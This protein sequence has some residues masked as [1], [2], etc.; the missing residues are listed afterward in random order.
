MCSVSDDGISPNLLMERVVNPGL[1]CQLELILTQLK[2]IDWKVIDIAFPHLT[3]GIVEI[4][5]I[6]TWGH[7]H[8]SCR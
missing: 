5:G 7:A 3:C 1:N 4:A 8:R 6:R 2:D